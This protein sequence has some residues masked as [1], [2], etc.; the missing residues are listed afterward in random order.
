MKRY[1]S[2]KS[3]F[4]WLFFTCNLVGSRKRQLQHAYICLVRTLPWSKAAFPPYHIPST[5]ENKQ[6]SNSIFENSKQKEKNNEYRRAYCSPYQLSWCRQW[7]VKWIITKLSRKV[8]LHWYQVIN[9]KSNLIFLY[10]LHLQLLSFSDHGDQLL[11]LIP[12]TFA[13]KLPTKA[14]HK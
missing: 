11:Y 10:L 3:S 6:R 2:L 1:S 13:I 9:G 7:Y 14:K 12:F 5:W 8:K 4:P